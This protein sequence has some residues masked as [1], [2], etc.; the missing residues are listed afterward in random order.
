MI[1]WDPRALAVLERLERAGFRAVLVGGCVRDRLLGLSSHDYDVAASAL[2]EQ[3]EAACADLPCVETGI[4]HGTV[5]VLSGGLPVEVTT[6]RREGG[7]SDHRRPDRVEFTQSLE[8]DLARR[9]FTVN[10]MAWERN[11]RVTDPFGGRADLEQRLVRCVGEP[12]RRFEED[13]LR[14]LRGLRLAAQLGFSL[15]PDTAAAL[16]RHIPQLS[17]VAR[18]R[19]WAELVRLLCSPGAGKILLDFPEAAVQAVPELGP[20]VGFDQRNPHHLWDVYTHSVKTLE[21]VPPSPAL[22]LAALLHDAGKPACFTLDGAGVGHFYGHAQKSAALARAALERLRAP[23]G[24]RDRAVSLVERHH[25]PV[26]ASEKWAGRWLSRLGPDLFFDLLA[27][28]RADALACAPDGGGGL[29]ALDGAQALARALLE[30][31]PC[32]TLKDLAVNGR[33]A[34]AAGL[35]GPEIGRALKKLLEQA[36]EGTLPNDRAVLLQAL[37]RLKKTGKRH[38]SPAR[39]VRGP[40]FV[41]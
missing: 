10:A 35:E 8:E 5:T 29:A 21:G 15:H 41:L 20:C 27:L 12:G 17:L 34:L 40:G 37:A 2:P 24:V 26:E 39:A 14:V 38:K 7:Y 18:E 32:L 33:D 11:G 28:K 1:G 23:G 3:V 36:A 13:A 6:F 25:L 22:R 30:R 9:D 16:R 19:I 31:S 4:R